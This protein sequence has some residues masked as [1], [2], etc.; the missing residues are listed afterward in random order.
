MCTYNRTG[1]G[2]GKPQPPT[3]PHMAA[4]LGMI[5]L[6]ILGCRFNQPLVMPRSATAVL[7]PSVVRQPWYITRIHFPRWQMSAETRNEEAVKDGVGKWEAGAEG[8]ETVGLLV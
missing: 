5:V 2:A 4:G 8:S 7:V 3:L 1:V 6:Y